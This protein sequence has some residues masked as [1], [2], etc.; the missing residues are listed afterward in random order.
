[1]YPYVA[2]TLF[3]L[4]AIFWDR[5]VK[6]ITAERCLNCLDPFLAP[7]RSLPSE[8]PSDSCARLFI[9]SWYLA[10]YYS[11]TEGGQIAEAMPSYGPMMALP[12]R[13]L[14]RP[15]S[16]RVFSLRLRSWRVLSLNS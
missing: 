12:D 9:S 4:T 2:F 8:N 11:L 10:R 14:I 5:G 15:P 16:N 7:G 13:P 6:E 3:A 1:M